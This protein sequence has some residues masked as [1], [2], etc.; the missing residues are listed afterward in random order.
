MTNRTAVVGLTAGAATVADNVNQFTDH[1]AELGE[2]LG[3]IELVQPQQPN[4]I[5][6]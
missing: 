3:A 1:L 6:P 5:I 4:I 2:K